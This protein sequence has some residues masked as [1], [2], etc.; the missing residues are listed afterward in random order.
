M[1][2]SHARA[3]SAI[4]ALAACAASSAALARDRTLQNACFSAQ[5]LSALPGERVIAKGDHRFDMKKLPAETQAAAAITPEMR[6]AIRRVDLPAGEK[7]I[8]LTF[9]LCEQRGEVAGYDGDLIDTLRREN[10]RATLFAG[11][12]WMRSHQARTQQLMTDPLFE[13]ANHSDTHPNMRKLEG[14]ALLDEISAPQRTF[15]AIRTGLAATQ[16]AAKAPDGLQSVAPRLGL[17]RF[18]F[19]ACNPVA[20]NAVNDAGMLAIQWDNSTGDPDPNQSADA[21][22]HAMVQRTKPGSIIIAHANGRGWNTAAALPIAI[23][24]LKAMG[25]T[26]VTVSELLTRGKPVIAETCYDSKPG[27]TDR[28]DFLGGVKPAAPFGSDVHAS[29]TGG[30]AKKSR[31]PHSS[32][33][34]SVF[35]PFSSPF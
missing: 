35:N 22:A 1:R 7:L 28:Y 30:T 18:P 24:K 10:V 11:G 25:Y 31:G 34:P 15:E 5:A 23:P 12:K 8:A 13:I 3:L 17:F 9:D 29:E 19:G 16:C 4:M 32:Y 21:I 6:G 2:T 33:E 14:A 27:D 20:M 26:F